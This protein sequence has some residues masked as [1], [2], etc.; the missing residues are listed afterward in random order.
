MSTDAA[1]RHSPLGR[2]F[3]MAGDGS[4][5]GDT[6]VVISERPF[7]G[8]LNLRGNPDDTG[9]TDAAATVLGLALPT[10]P[11]KVAVSGGTLALWLGPDEWLVVTPPGAQARLTESLEAA[12]EGM[13]AA[14]TNVTGGQTVITLS[15]PRARDVLARG[16]PLDLHQSV[17]KPG[18]C[19]QTLVAKA[20]VTVRCVDESPSFELIVRRSFAEYLA[21]WLHDAALEYGPSVAPPSFRDGAS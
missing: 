14:V 1:G 19:S 7:L 20:S 5:P 21:L 12:L 13:H 11:N 9:F 2:F 3:D 17:F 6:A 18:D 8:H 16:C 4:Q 15:G 10:E